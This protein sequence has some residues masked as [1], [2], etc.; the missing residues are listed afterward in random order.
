ME[1]FWAGLNAGR[2]AFNEALKF[3][4][5]ESEPKVLQC[6]TW[7]NDNFF[8]HKSKDEIKRF[9]KIGSGK[10]FGDFLFL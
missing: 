7:L 8:L 10:L 9:G 5:V 4:D 1:W 3:A 2:K 6:V